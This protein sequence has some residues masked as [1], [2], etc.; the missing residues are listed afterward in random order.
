MSLPPENELS[1]PQTHRPSFN[2]PDGTF[3]SHN[4][5]IAKHLQA[6]YAQNQGLL[7]IALSQLFF[8]LMY[9]SVKTLTML[10]PPVP[11]FEVRLLRN[12]N[13]L[14]VLIHLGSWSRCEWA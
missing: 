10:D 11:T 1:R 13:S 5:T 9:M 6:F 2:F 14:Q 3:D 7:I 8:S 4:R 12:P